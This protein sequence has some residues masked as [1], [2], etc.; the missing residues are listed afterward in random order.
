MNNVTSAPRELELLYNYFVLQPGLGPK[1]CVVLYNTMD[2]QQD[3]KGL[4]LCEL[5]ETV[6]I[7]SDHVS[8]FF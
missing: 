7:L 1:Q 5:I 3:T 8:F 6:M 4:R 2:A